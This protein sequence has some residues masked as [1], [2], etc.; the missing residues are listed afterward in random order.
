MR[1]AALHP[2]KSNR[3]KYVPGCSDGLKPWRNVQQSASCETLNAEYIS[4]THAAM[5]DILPVGKVLGAFPLVTVATGHSLAIR[6]N[7]CCD[8]DH[9]GF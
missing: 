9:H 1:R 2:E 4:E 7:S 5:G 3:L 6:A 8:T